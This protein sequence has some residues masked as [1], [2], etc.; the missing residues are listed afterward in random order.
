[1]NYALLIAF[2][3]PPLHGSSGLQRTLGFARHLH[4]GHWAPLILSAHPRA[5][6][7]MSTDLVGAVP[8]GVPVKRAFALDTAKHLALHGRY[9]DWMALPD[10]WVSWLLGAIPSGLAMI[11]RYRPRLI[12]STYPIA[13]AHIIA[14]ALHRISGI[15]WVAD[16]RDPM[17]E[18][19]PRTGEMAP[20]NRT[21][22]RARLWVERL[23]VKHTSRI[24]L[25][26]QGAKRI[27]AERY[28]EVPDTHWVIIPNG[29]EES[30]FNGCVTTPEASP[31]HKGPL[32][33]LHSGII[34]PTPDRDPGALFDAVATLRNAGRISS[35]RLRIVLRATAYDGLFRPMI[36]AHGIEDIVSLA[37]AIPY[38]DALKEMC[39]VDGLLVFQGYTSNPAIP[40]KVYEY[41]RTGKPIL[42]MIDAEGD[43]AALLRQLGIGIQVPLDD[44]HRIAEGLCE[45][46]DQIERGTA[47]RAEIRTVEEFSR[48]RGAQAL[49]RLFDD[50]TGAGAR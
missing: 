37:P 16:F 10:R 40:A 8:G 44:P 17:V 36:E 13:T 6:T 19:D 20:P 1:M 47:P 31:K 25:C 18:R 41:L 45:F 22:R 32:V 38:R 34:Y 5:Y 9:F 2:H 12:W 15:P 33:L 50:V 28:P 4:A 49:A 23:C 42:A 14:W 24:V 48:A 43:T 26:T 27:C 7:A 3:F 30:D 11:R 21:L 39:E 35:E 46:L 29:Y